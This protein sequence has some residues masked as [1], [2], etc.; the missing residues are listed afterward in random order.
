MFKISKSCICLNSAI[1]LQEIYLLRG[2][3]SLTGN[4]KMWLWMVMWQCFQDEKKLADHFVILYQK[5]FCHTCMF[6]KHFVIHVCFRNILSYMYVSE[7]FCHMYVWG[8]MWCSADNIRYNL[9]TW[10][11]LSRGCH[12]IYQVLFYF[13]FC[14]F[15]IFLLFLPFQFPCTN[16]YWPCSCPRRDLFY[17]QRQ[18]SLPSIHV[19]LS[20]STNQNTQM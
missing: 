18:T 4:I 19:F 11:A 14:L 16:S 15:F 1:W 20:Y 7:T 8:A 12:I 13:I 6:Q 2:F 5:S 9:M 3:F 17:L 10:S